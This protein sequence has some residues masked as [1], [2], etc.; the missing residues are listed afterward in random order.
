[1]NKT[2]LITVDVAIAAYNAEKNIKRLVESMLLQKEVNFKLNK[3]IV[4]SDS[5]SDKTVSISQSIS[6]KRVKVIDSHARSGF[7]GALISLVKANITDVL[8]LLNDDIVV[9]DEFFIE[10][11]IQPFIKENNIGLV[12]GNPQAFKSN[13]FISEAVRSGYNAYK[14]ISDSTRKGNN[15]YTVD[16]KAL[17]FSK[18][19]TKKIK[20]PTDYRIMGNVDKFIYFS[21][22]KEKLNYRYV[23]NAIMYFKCPSTIQDFTKWQTRNYKSNKYMVK[24]V[25]G[26]LADKEYE[27]DQTKFRL[28]KFLEFLKNPIGSIVILMLGL[29][30]SYKASIAKDEFSLT[31]DLVQTTKDL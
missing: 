23:S 20:F 2:K 10:K 13:N 5:S 24:S 21:C 28:Y 31:W 27:M 26:K 17:C 6:D 18:D 15:V 7:A 14:R 9:T 29:Y 16:G 8:I 1:M 4:N 11:I 22:I 25:W 12:C 19:F 3:V 30:C